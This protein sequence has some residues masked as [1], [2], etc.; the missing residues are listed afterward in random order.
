MSQT[1]KVYSE[2]SMILEQ[3]EKKN[4]EI[5]STVKDYILQ[6]SGDFSELKQKL[7][8]LTSHPLVTQEKTKEKGEEQVFHSE[9]YKAFPDLAV[10]QLLQI[11]SYSAAAEELKKFAESKIDQSANQYAAKNKSLRQEFAEQL[12]QFEKCKKVNDDAAFAYKSA[13]IAL[14]EAEKRN[15]PNIQK[16]KDEFIKSRQKAIQI[17][18]EASDKTEEITCTMETLLTKLEDLEKSRAEELRSI[19]FDFSNTLLSIANNFI[20]SSAEMNEAVS[21]I[22]MGLDSHVIASFDR[23]RK[24]EADDFFQVLRVDPLA[25]RFLNK[26]NLYPEEMIQG[27]KLFTVTEDYNGPSEHLVGHKGEIVCG[28]EP[29]GDLYFCKNI[30]FSVGFLPS[31]ILEPYY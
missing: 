11:P 24:P 21:E 30:N 20:M 10:N 25:S 1:F 8:K 4:I 9:L 27:G 22:P 14:Q 26:E 18:K 28:L 17:Y 3:A 13:G 19:L 31:N 5:M 7:V 2:I 15:D 23:F 29:K 16:F 12:N 6:F